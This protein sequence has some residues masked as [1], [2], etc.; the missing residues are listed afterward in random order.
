MR[1]FA[2]LLAASLL[3]VRATAADAFDAAFWVWQRDEPLSKNETAELAMQGIHTLYWHV[4][5]LENEGET[6]HW[7][8]RFTAPQSSADLRIVPVVRLTSREKN[9]FSPRLL[10]ALLDAL[11]AVTKDAKAELQID[12]DCPDRL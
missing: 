8:G 7:K 1:K 12:V 4:G 3:C 11:S 10:Q 5:E 6:W 2:V 9:P